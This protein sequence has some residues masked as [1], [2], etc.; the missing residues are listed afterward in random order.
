LAAILVRDSPD[1]SPVLAHRQ[2]VEACG[3]GPDG[4]ILGSAFA[5]E[6]AQFGNGYVREAPGTNYITWP[7]RPKRF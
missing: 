1:R 6:P 3:I 2:V 4:A 5:F 7:V